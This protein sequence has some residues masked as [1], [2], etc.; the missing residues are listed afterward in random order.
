[1]LLIL[2]GSLLAAPTTALA[3]WGA[4]ALSMGGAFVAVADDAYATY[5]NQ[6]GLA[7]LTSS[8]VALTDVTKW[9]DLNY[10]LMG[11]VSVPLGSRGGVGFAC[12]YNKDYPGDGWAVVDLYYQVGVGWKVWPLSN[13]QGP[14]TFS[15]GLAGK[16]L[17]KCISAGAGR[18]EA[19]SDLTDVDV[20]CL[21][22]FGPQVA[23]R[24]RMF[25]L[26]ILVQDLRESGFWGGNLRYVRNVRPGLCFRPDD[27][28]ILSAEFYDVTEE[29][30]V[31]PGVR[32]GF[33][34]WFTLGKT[35]PFVALRGG[36]YHLNQDDMRAYT[37]GLGCRPT[38]AGKAEFSY[39]L[40]YWT[41]SDVATH[42]VSVDYRF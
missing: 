28:T 32:L 3:C 36:V 39:A 19:S 7:K 10:D 6:A 18:A 29:A 17:S 5:W 27:K 16:Y 1:M 37:F 2:W 14:V 4:R 38:K 24:Q 13:D 31:S 23:P 40:M 41:D 20:S 21:L 15:L 9:K 34:R 11:A 22:D 26:G 30:F 12:T 42:M 8:E 25:S 33:E 35:H